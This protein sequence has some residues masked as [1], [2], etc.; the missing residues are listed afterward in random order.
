[1]RMQEFHGMWDT[2]VYDVEVKSHL[3]DYAQSAMYFAD[4]R[5]DPNIVA[6]VALDADEETDKA[7]RLENPTQGSE[8]AA[9]GDVKPPVAASR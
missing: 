6:D 4:R 8:D 1:M 9:S 7:E 2:L 3:L 5:V